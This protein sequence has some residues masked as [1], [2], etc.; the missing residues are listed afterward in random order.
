[1]DGDPLAVKHCFLESMIHQKQYTT[2]M[3]LNRAA[4]A[5]LGALK[6]SKDSANFQTYVKIKAKDAA[7]L[8]F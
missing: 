6:N 4:T 8:F 5:P 1:M 7:K 3:V 2:A